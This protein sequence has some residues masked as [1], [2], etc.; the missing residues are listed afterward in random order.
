MTNLLSVQSFIIRPLHSIRQSTAAPVS[1]CTEA[2]SFMAGA[3]Q[4]PEFQPV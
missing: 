1:L 2:A 3:G 4:T